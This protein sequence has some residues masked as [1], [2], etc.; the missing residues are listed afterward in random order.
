MD[1]P[2]I[3]RTLRERL[4]MNQTEFGAVFGVAFVTVFRWESGRSSPYPRSKK[5]IIELCKEHNVPTDRFILVRRVEGN[6]K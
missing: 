6:S 2:S 5:K 3:I 1:W 4:G